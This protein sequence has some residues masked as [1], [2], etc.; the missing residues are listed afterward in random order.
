[1]RK[2]HKLVNKWDL[3]SLHTSIKQNLADYQTWTNCFLQFPDPAQCCRE[4]F[5]S[6]LIIT[7]PQYVKETLL[8]TY[9]LNMV[10]AIQPI[11]NNVSC[12][13]TTQFK[14]LNTHY[15]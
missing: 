13:Y 12:S 14:E 3:L 10:P 1:M 6:I 9:M 5:L 15:C 7:D 8:G 2:F 11:A 4:G